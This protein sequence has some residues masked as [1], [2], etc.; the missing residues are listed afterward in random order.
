MAIQ[1]SIVLLTFL[2]QFSSLQFSSLGLYNPQHTYFIN[3]GSDFDVTE[4]NNVYIGESNPTYP[5]TVFSKSS[6]VTSQSSSLSTPLSPLYQTA[7]IFP[8]KSFY[9]FK[10]VPNNTYMVRFHFFLFS[11]PT[12]LSTAK[13]NVSFPGFSL[14]QN[15]DINS[16]F[17]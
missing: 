16:A 9:E 17:N 13:F 14:L 6:K 3:C 8:S 1:Q 7:I 4:S 12:N 5:K 15:F 2:L 10:T 11:L